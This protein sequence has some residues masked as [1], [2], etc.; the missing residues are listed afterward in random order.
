MFYEC[1][2][3]AISLQ[4]NIQIIIYNAHVTFYLPII[5]QLQMAN[6]KVELLGS[7][8]YSENNV[9]FQFLLLKSISFSIKNIK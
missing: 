8:L 7:Q 3:S 6:W 2:V 5:H 1:W 9:L 4:I